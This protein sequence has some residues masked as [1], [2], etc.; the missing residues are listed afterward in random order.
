MATSRPDFH[1]GVRG[2]TSGGGYGRA[3]YRPDWGT[4]VAGLANQWAK[5]HAKRQAEQA[6]RAMG[7][8]Q[9]QKRG[10]WA[11]A[12]A[13]GATIRD[14]AA[15][16]PSIIGDTAFLGF[17][18]RTKTP[19]GYEDIL[20]DQG[21]PIAQRGPEG[22]AF[23]HPLAPEPEG[24]A[25]ETFEDVLNPHGFGGAAQRSSV[26]G[27]LINYQG[28]PSQPK[29]SERRTAKDQT[30]RLRYLDTGEPAFADALFDQGGT[31]KADAP[32]FKDRFAMARQLS[33]DW[34]ETV[35]PMQG[36]IDSSDRMNIGFK[37]A[38][39]GDMLAGSQAI[40]ISFNKL[41]DPTSVVRESEY[42]RSAT[43]QSALET[44]RG[45]A[46]KLAQGGAGV[47]LKELASYRR[48]GEEVVKKALESTVGPERKRIGR[49]VK[50]AN[51]DPALIFSGRFA[52]KPP[53]AQGMPPGPPA[54]LPQQGP[55]MPQAQATTA[56]PGVEALA[57]ALG[58]PPQAQAP[59]QAPAQAGM[60]LP[61]S[62]L[63]RQ[64]VED[65][66][67]LKPDA[68]RKQV[69]RMAEKLALDPN[70]YP[71]AEIDAAKIAFDKISGR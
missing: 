46:D 27:K 54:G 28:A 11:Q 13:G 21:Q 25:P 36:L 59:A 19:K 9:A 8:Q 47:T 67:T 23:A 20:D 10:A 63:E 70:A 55:A 24:P 57:K 52:P 58:G 16:D 22:R 60:G 45:Y 29:G 48:F 38:K 42:A 15:R 68:L 14:I 49:L 53:Q 12:I 31:P 18:D 4:A 5:A 65:Y 39:A 26:S 34:Q 51:I 69:A 61:A 2:T 64:R 32:T 43:G 7:E 66:A 71:Q 33:G 6:E 41:L 35:R 37:M 62:S 56:T 30:G 50:Y 1:I 3:N 40:L 17:L 44:L